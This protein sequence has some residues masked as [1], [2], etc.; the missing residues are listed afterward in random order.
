MP[1]FRRILQGT[2]L[3]LTAT[4]LP[5]LAAVPSG[6]HPRIWLT[7]QIVASWQAIQSVPNSPV[8]RAIAKCNDARLDPA[9]YSDGQFQGFR[10][11]EALDA[12][13]VAYKTTKSTQHRDTAIKYWTALMDDAQTVGDGDGPC[14]PNTCGSP[15]PFGIAA[16]D[17]G[18]SMR[19]YVAWTALGY[20]WLHDDLSPTLRARYAVRFKQWLAFHMDPDSFE[21]AD[22]G[23]NYHAGHVLAVT[24]MAIGHA[25]EMDAAAAGSGT[26]L[27]TYVTNEM[28]GH[29]MAAAQAPRR[30]MLGGD[31]AEGW[32]YGPL[33]VASY[34]LAGRAMIQQGVQQPWI[35]SWLHAVLIRQ[36][37]A[38][39]PNNR[40]FIGGD[41]QNE[42]PTLE[43]DPLPL[44]GV[45]AGPAAATDKAQAKGEVA[46]L[47]LPT[48][49]LN[50][51]FTLLTQSLVAA[52]TTPAQTIN[53]AVLPVSYLAAGSG[54]FYVRT[55][56]A[57]TGTWL[58][59]QCRG[60][61]SNHQH[62]DAGNI[63]LTRGADDLLVDPSPY[64]SQST[65]TG[66]APTMSQP[67]FNPEYRPSQADWGETNP[68]DIV[69]AGLSTRF[70]L[71]R[72]SPS[73]GVAVT[74]CDYG[75]QFRFQDN[76][77]AIV[78]AARR[79]VVLLPGTT[80]ASVLV[81]DAVAT[82]A[83]YSAT[84][85]PLLLRF[86][87]LGTFVASGGDRARAVVGGSALLVRRLAGAATTAVHPVKVS[88]TCGSVQGACNVGR[89]ASSEWNIQVPGPN[90]SSV[91]LL[92]VDATTAAA[93]L[94]ATRTNGPVQVTTVQ[95]DGKQ[96]AVVWTAVGARLDSYEAPALN[97]VHVVLD[98]PAGNR[99]TVTA[100]FNKAT[101]TC[102]MQLATATGT[103]GFTSLPLIVKVSPTCVVSE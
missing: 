43:V 59:S 9:D 8:N 32:E 91:H 71:A 44:Y 3:F 12:C 2:L 54:N 64:G 92:D 101:N 27:W 83:P 29:I 41:V 82:R 56:F 19:T 17:A 98:P 75:G 69:P 42:A 1:R 103:S 5:A 51:D 93:P 90:P 81:R 26:T 65:L 100:T 38:L 61:I 87:S 74:R 79:E 70:L 63:T 47:A 46:R 96:Y 95:R 102:R 13:L 30:P 60:V 52:E 18:Y 86:R 33:S 66:N 34:A 50:G 94:A 4:A 84:P 78:G 7:P 68:P 21:R 15:T 89:F 10:W 53:R 45:I 48:P 23:S 85:S 99:V 97:G 14:Y 80:G 72:S 55:S 25:D 58:V 76:P 39:T 40:T 28:W 62:V 35:G 88:D 11:V 22:T 6:P 67:H 31:W 24:L 16:Q 37:Y 36:V 49:S 73:T 20:D 77:S 57:P